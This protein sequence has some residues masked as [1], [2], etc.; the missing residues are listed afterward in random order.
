MSDQSFIKDQKP[1][2]QQTAANQDQKAATKSTEDLLAILSKRVDDKESHIQKMH[3]KLDLQAAT[4]A[5]Q[6]DLLEKFLAGAAKLQP[7]A[8]EAQQTESTDTSPAISPDKLIEQVEAKIT[9]RLTQRDKQA[10]KDANLKLVAD[11]LYRRYGDKTD[12]MVKSIAADNDMTFAEAYEFA[13]TRPKAFL[14]LLPPSTTAQQSSR[15]G[16][17]SS[18]LQNQSSASLPKVDIHNTKS[19]VAYLRAAEDLLSKQG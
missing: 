7:G 16:V 13:Q 4:I 17:N 19:L 14:K 2:Q 10:A 15:T 8:T 1:D 9:E 18:G 11:E 6:H 3:E 5:K 12:D